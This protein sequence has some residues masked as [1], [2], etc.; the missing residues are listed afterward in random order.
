MMDVQVDG[1]EVR[2]RLKDDVFQMEEPGT[3]C[4][5]T[6]QAQMLRRSLNSLN[7]FQ[8]LDDEGEDG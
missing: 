3:L 8:S 4:L 1:R 5:T 7:D 2:V 6:K